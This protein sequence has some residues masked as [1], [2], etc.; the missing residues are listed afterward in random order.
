MATL[1]PSAGET[2][3]VTLPVGGMT[4]AACQARV[5]RALQEAPGVASATVNLMTGV[6][7]VSYDPAATAPANLVETIRDTGYESHLP[8]EAVA[9]GEEDAARDRAQREEFETLRRKAV[10][11]GLAGVVAM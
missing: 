7:A 3:R 5:Q 8:A 4:C 9:A 2:A 6:A 10:I 1:A 11:S